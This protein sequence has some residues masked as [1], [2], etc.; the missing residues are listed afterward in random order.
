MKPITILGS[1]NVDFIM[2]L[3][4][5]PRLG[6]TVTDGIF[7]QTYGGKGANQAV[8]AARAG[9]PTRCLASLGA[10]HYGREMAANFQQE[11]MDVAG[12][13]HRAD[14]PSGSALV[15][16]GQGGGNYL[17]VAPGSNHAW[18]EEEVREDAEKIQSSAMLVLQMEVPVEVVRAAIRI[19]GQAQ[20]PVLL[21]YAPCHLVDTSLLEG[22]SVLVVNETEAEALCGLEVGSAEQ[23][24][25]AAKE[26]RGL[27]VEA[28]II[29]LG[30]RGALYAGPEGELSVPAFPVSTVDTTAAGDTFCGAFAVAQSE[31]RPIEDSLRFASAAAACCVTKLGAQPSI[32]TRDEIEG[33]SSRL[34]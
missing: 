27:G 14:L 31:G 16:I 8:A 13:R 33:L 1:A 22:V 20:V 11:G 32:P 15:M 5:L 10:D 25:A 28:V 18:T 3:P 30:A 12:L 4:H 24:S 23:A 9:A 2:K 29:T 26:L 7:L 21:N 34:G 17:S 19:A 6:E